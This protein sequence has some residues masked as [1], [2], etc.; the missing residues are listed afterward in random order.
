MTAQVT[1]VLNTAKDVLTV[2][3]SALGNAGRNGNYR[4]GVYDP[5]SGKCNRPR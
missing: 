3:A 2:P 1:I 5:A 4:V